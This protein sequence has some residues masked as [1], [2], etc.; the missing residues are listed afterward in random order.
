MKEY[1]RKRLPA[2]RSAI[3]H[4]TSSFVWWVVGGMILGALGFLAT[5]V[6]VPDRYSTDPSYTH[7]VLLPMLAAFVSAGG[8]LGLIAVTVSNYF[9]GKSIQRE[10]ELF[11][12]PNLPPARPRPDVPGIDLGVRANDSVDS[13]RDP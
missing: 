7:S 9:E 1:P 11:S 5:L 12:G 8:A 4:G 2:I 10:R 3:S 13:S 6:A